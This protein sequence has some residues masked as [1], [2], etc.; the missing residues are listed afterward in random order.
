MVA[1]FRGINV[2]GYRKVSMAELHSIA[3]S[4]GFRQIETYINS[5]NL[6]FE[7]GRVGVEKPTSQLE[8]AVQEK[9]NVSVDVIVRTAKQW[10][11]Y[12]SQCP[13]P[14]AA[15]VRPNL[16]MIGLAKIRQ[17]RDTEE[18][19]MERAGRNERVKVVGDA[20]WVD[21]ANGAGRSRLTPSFIQK[22]VGSPLTL[23]NWR[24]VLKLEEMLS[25]KF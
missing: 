18:L 2:G 9:L 8:M 5:G 10:Q 7:S 14:E 12:T 15:M 24:T 4:L 22:V 1:L 17:A 20:I 13:F 11:S 6:V 23:R 19:L 25:G 16:L 21:F 3:A